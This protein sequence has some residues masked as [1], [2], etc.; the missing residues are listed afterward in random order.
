MPSIK[1]ITAQTEIALGNEYSVA[2][3][4]PRN[5]QDIRLANK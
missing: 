3:K 2:A 1:I 5:R 4:I